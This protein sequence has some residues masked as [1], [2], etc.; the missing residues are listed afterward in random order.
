MRT[1]I[2]SNHLDAQLDDGLDPQFLAALA[3]R[4]RIN[5]LE[6]AKTILLW[7]PD[8]KEE[9]GTL[10]LRVRR[11]AQTLGAKL[12]VVHPRRTGLDDRAAYKFTYKP[13][14]GAETLRMLSAG[15]GGFAA[16]RE[17]LN[18][19]PVVALVGRTGLAE[20]PRL[21]EAVAGFVR[22]LPESTVLTLARRSNVYGALD[23]GVAP[24]LLPGRV[25]ADDQAGRELLS[26]IWGELPDV[27]GRGARGILE[28]TADGAIKA[29]ILQGADPSRDVP[30]GSLAQQALAEAEFVL[31]IDLF[32]TDSAAAADVI[33]PAAA[34]TE[35]DGTVTN[36]EGR[37]QKVNRIVAP[38]GQ[39]R[40]DWSILDDLSRRGFGS[41]EVVAKEI[42]AA[43]PA[44]AGLEWAAV[45][46]EAGVVVPTGEAVQP[47]HYVPV[48]SSESSVVSRQS[49]NGAFAFH[50]A[51]TLY[52]DGVLL[53]NGLSLHKL[54][55]GGFA[56]IT[57]NDANRLGV[58][59]GDRVAVNDVTLLPG[60]RSCLCAVQPTRRSLSW[61]RTR[62]CRQSGRGGHHSHPWGE[63]A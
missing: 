36:L 13:G 7:G 31:A 61:W 30:D 58:V 46:T 40:S 56:A 16:A 33:L 28:G 14:E 35:K 4:G 52:D 1:A 12:I 6:S 3:G 26:S 19:G 47:L 22:D 32:I 55:P 2:G 45:E 60:G 44:Y 59:E 39:A 21:A 57:S 50:S 42:A 25:S 9:N 17:I 15:E 38:P 24:T 18:E 62:S 53:R 29:L 11:A 10:Y 54:A 27:V 43:A 48:V 37:V 23:M 63:S 20:D 5:D 41:V 34:F 8:L 49:S 51:R